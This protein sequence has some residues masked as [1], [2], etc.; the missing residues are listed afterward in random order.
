VFQS[1]IPLIHYYTNQ[2]PVVELAFI[3]GFSHILVAL[4]FFHVPETIITSI[5]GLLDDCEALMLGLTFFFLPFS[6]S[7]IVLAL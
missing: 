1:T 4:K 5:K 6:F 2:I 3:S 7:R